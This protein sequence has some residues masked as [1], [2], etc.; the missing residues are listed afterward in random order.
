MS[1][2]NK[3]GVLQRTLI[4]SMVAI[5]T[6]GIS[7]LAAD[8]GAVKVSDEQVAPYQLKII[9]RGESAPRGDN[10][11]TAGR[12]ENRRADVRLL[13]KPQ[14]KP[15]TETSAI[16]PGGG[17]VW[18]TRDPASLDRLLRIT[19]GTTVSIENGK[20][21]QP[22]EFDLATNYPAFIE[23]AEVLVFRGG[24]SFSQKPL[25]KIPVKL[26][27]IST[28]VSWNAGDAVADV[29]S[30]GDGKNIFS[31]LDHGDEFEVAL[32]VYDGR[33]NYDQTHAST[34]RV[35]NAKRKLVN[36]QSD[37][38]GAIDRDSSVSLQSL[39]SVADGI[40]DINSDLADLGY[41]PL[42]VQGISVE[43][44]RI[45]V[46]GQDLGLRSGYKN[47]V[48]VNGDAID[49]T[50]DGQFIAEY[51]L[52]SGTHQF[53]VTADGD[54]E[55][56]AGFEQQLTAE[57]D[58]NYFF[59]VGLADLTVGETNVSGSVEPLS[60]DEGRFDGDIFVDGRLAFYL[61]GKVKGKYLITGQLDTGTEDVSELFDNF[62]RQD[63]R[64]VFRRLDPDEYYLVY[65]DDS[66]IYDDT[67]SQG[68]FYV[69]V[70]WDRSRAIWGNFN[71]AFSG[72]ELAAFNRSLYGAQLQYR[73][74]DNTGQ[75]DTKTELSVF[76]SEAQTAFRH[77]EF[78]GTGGSLYFLRDRDIVLGSE[79]VWVE[80][81]QRGG[82]RVIERVP[83]IV[84]RDYDIDEFQGRIILNR[85]L[86][87]VAGQSG[88]SIIRDEP[89]DGNETYLVVDYEFLPDNFDSGNV[90]AGL[91]ARRWLGD[92]VALGASLAH[93][94][95]DGDDYNVQGLDLTLKKTGNT[96]FRAEWARSEASQTAGSF[97]SDDGGISFAAFNSN[98]ATSSG[99][100]F[101]IEGRVS[102]S[103]IKRRV[104]KDEELSEPNSTLG[105]WYKYRDA[106]F[107]VASLDTGA[108]TTEAGVEFISQINDRTTLTGRAT[109]LERDGESRETT[110]SIQGD[111]DISDRLRAGVEIRK[112]R[113]ENLAQ[114]VDSGATLAAGKFSYDLSDPLTIFGVVQTTLRE[115]GDFERNNQY[116][117]G[118]EYKLNDRLLLNG[119]VST[120]DRGDAVLAGAE[121]LFSDTYSVYS[122]LSHEISDRSVIRQTATL[123]QRKQL[124]KRL[125]VFTEHQFTHEDNRQGAAHTLGL[126]RQFTR[127][128]SA[129]LSLQVG[130]FEDN[131]GGTTDRDAI[132]VGVNLKRDA[133]VAAS[134]LEYRRDRS[135]SVDTDQIVTTNRFEYRKSVAT[136]WQGVL[137]ASITDDR[138]G[139]QE[140]ARFLEA[141]IGFAYRP[142]THDRLN[143]LGRLTYLFDLPPL[144]Q[145]SETDRRS[146][147]GSLEGIYAIN[148]KWDIGAK[149]AHREGEQRIQRGSGI[150]FGNDASLV[151]LR[152]RYRVPFGL[153]L[154]GSWRWL[155]SDATDSL[156][157]GALITFG[158]TVGDNLSLSLGYNFTDFDDDL[159]DD[160]FEA[161]GWFLNLV[162]RY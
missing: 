24:D 142:V 62:N 34:L 11:T 94:T 137:D 90:T 60:V 96:Y 105:A 12:Q 61:K 18:I 52:P 79:K 98:G 113:E 78:L 58:S 20:P 136:R 26:D 25:F 15:S 104:S 23:E 44:A 40:E 32:R 33:G 39:D 2:L 85:P 22:L 112:V 75:G 71:T 65:G 150:W 124:S 140:D 146:L 133:L 123:G 82:E 143:M 153:E 87:T 53:D 83:L 130:N 31:T 8:E 149:F 17:S 57:I 35:V 158:T 132:S 135:S 118:A 56:L 122:N 41:E 59:L 36:E 157:Q 66:N 54:H 91:R 139:G 76:A 128:L 48:S 1:I 121:Y 88:P 111:Y 46:H 129:N 97:A 103:D 21:V 38:V 42:A 51:L 110:A 148:A 106:D 151:G 13:R 67:D 81:R 161:R 7:A 28:Q 3:H 89:I 70:E 160:S 147:I 10:K 84:G 125:K 45:R 47:S 131:D 74:T 29:D 109:L 27:G 99:N 100:A 30:D 9:K 116:R 162:G 68:K 102:F 115:T 145:S 50:E 73:S 6:G 108:D 107:S 155:S 117:L 80:V 16:L 5:A 101:S 159:G 64:S 37:T 19:T 120:G 93:E 138:L 119:E 63:P 144:S 126:D 4:S 127:Y 14:A 69:R 77:N 95:R 141:G 86:L 156:Q 114:S 154:L 55:A 92:Y 152:A 43:G 72:T 134:R 49:V